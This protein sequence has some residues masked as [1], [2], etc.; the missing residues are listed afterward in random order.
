MMAVLEQQP[1]LEGLVTTLDANGAP[2]LAVMGP[3]INFAEKKMLL[4]PFPTSQTCV[5]LC[6]HSQGVFHIHDDMLL[7]ALSAIGKNAPAVFIPAHRIAGVLL[8]DCCNAF[9]FEVRSYDKSQARV[10]IVADIVCDHKL[11]DFVGFN[12]ARHAVIEAAILCTRLHLL[13]GQ[14]VAEEIAQLRTLVEKT[15]GPREQEAFLTLEN[16]HAQFQEGKA[17]S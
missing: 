6:R 10:Q 4:R 8:Q 11:R 12:R 7:Y 16:Y 2:H 1:V 13:P 5:N 14:Q 15:G 3:R 9:E 17:K